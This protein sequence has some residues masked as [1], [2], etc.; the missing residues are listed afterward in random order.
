MAGGDIMHFDIK[1]HMGDRVHHRTR[2]RAAGRCEAAG[3]WWTGQSPGVCQCLFHLV[4]TLCPM[5]RAGNGAAV[6]PVM[7]IERTLLVEGQSGWYRE[8]HLFVL[9]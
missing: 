2:Q 5:L 6:F 7:E 8:A 9:E 4:N 3:A 1:R